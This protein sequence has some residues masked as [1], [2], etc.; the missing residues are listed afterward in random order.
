MNY[1]ERILK[2]WALTEELFAH[3][4]RR[5]IVDN[6]SIED[7]RFKQMCDEYYD[8]IRRRIEQCEALLKESNGFLVN[9]TLAQLYDRY[10]IEASADHFYRRPVRYYAIRA[11]RKNRQSIEAWLLLADCYAWLSM[12]GPE[13]QTMPLIRIEKAQSE[14]P[15]TPA[16]S[17]SYLVKSEPLSDIQKSKIA[18]IEKAIRC[19]QKASRLNPVDECI[20]TR[21]KH[22]LAQR[23]QEFKL[24]TV[25]RS[26]DLREPQ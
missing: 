16:S 4:D 17:V 12:I 21:L 25:V 18:S 11:I 22:Y 19:V 15:K 14:E 6:D 9:Y 10:D 20:Q 3:F 23:N 7:N 1:D 5:G 2:E 26:L 8:E 13:S 24:E